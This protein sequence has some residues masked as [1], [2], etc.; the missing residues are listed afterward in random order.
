M[1]EEI[2]VISLKV[3]THTSLEGTPMM[4]LEASQEGWSSIQHS[5]PKS[6]EFR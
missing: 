3:L 2:F 1:W 5:N 4:L 6:P